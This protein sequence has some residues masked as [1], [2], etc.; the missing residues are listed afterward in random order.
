M[1]KAKLGTKITALFAIVVILSVGL[2]GV[3]SGISQNNIIKKQLE[4]ST[5]ESA[6]SLADK[7]N[8]LLLSK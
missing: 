5:Q 1:K 4:Y 8:E 7:I 3:V 2:S 6:S